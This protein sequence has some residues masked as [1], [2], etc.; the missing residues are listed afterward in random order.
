MALGLVVEVI[1][2]SV[3]I[4]MVAAVLRHKLAAPVSYFLMVA[5]VVAPVA[6]SLLGNQAYA[7]VV[8]S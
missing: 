2:L 5:N 4:N 6:L 8:V 3:D 7:T 1:V